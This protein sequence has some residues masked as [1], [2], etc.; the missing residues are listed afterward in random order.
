[1]TLDGTVPRTKLAF[2]MARVSEL[3]KKYGLRIAN[4]FHAGD[5]NLHPCILYD[6]RI[7]E[8]VQK[9]HEAGNEVMHLC[10]E[11][12]GTIS[13]EHGIG[14]EKSKFM[15]YIFSD[16][17]LKFMKRIKTIFDPLNICNPGKIFPGEDIPHN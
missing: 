7:E 2:A 1:L 13:G 9:M 14:M 4:V 16:E 10:A 17:D 8:E 3:S 5:G 6:E 12:G 15:R 11:L